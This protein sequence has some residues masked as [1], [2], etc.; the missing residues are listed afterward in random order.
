[1]SFDV[2][3]PLVALDDVLL[4]S[5]AADLVLVNRL[6]EPGE[7]GTSRSPVIRLDVASHDGPV[8]TSATSVYVSTGGGPEVLA[9]DGSSFQPG[10][11][12]ATSAV[13]NPDASTLRVVI[14]MT[15]V[16]LGGLQ[17]VTVRVDTESSGG[18]T[19]NESYSFET[20]DTFGPEIASVQGRADEVVRVTFNEQV[21]AAALLASSYSIAGVDAP[22]AAVEVVGVTQAGPGVFDLALGEP[23]TFGRAYRLTVAG[24]SD[25]EG[26]AI[27]APFDQAVFTAFQPPWP[28]LR[29]WSHWR[30]MLAEKNRN[31]DLSGDLE[32][33]SLVVQDVIDL[34]L[35][36]VDRWTDIIDVDK[37]P[38]DFVDAILCDLGNPFDFDLTLNQKR[39]LGRLLIAIYK[40]KGTD[41]GIINAVRLLLGVE[42]T[43]EANSSW[44]LVLDED[45]L[46]GDDVFL[47]TDDLASKLTFSVVADTALSDL[48]RSRI[49]E[50]GDYMKPARTHLAAVVDVPLDLPLDHVI[51]DVSLLDEEWILH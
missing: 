21:D 24:V 10:F 50:I 44:G 33:F 43:I 5:K 14:D 18:T 13:S 15:L 28:A 39:K 23:A 7:T 2:I 45:E 25:L 16:P 27:A 51:L 41:P 42:V 40:Q 26:N 37:A 22:T 12:G 36:G 1:M 17:T 3:L 35:R 47:G 31:E 11:S 8:V 20:E 49:E 34:L 48:V 4:D 46:E 6:P 30:H 9:F 32:R 19:L 38:E 29:R